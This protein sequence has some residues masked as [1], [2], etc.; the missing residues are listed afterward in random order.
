MSTYSFLIAE[1]TTCVNF[2]DST[3]HA[4]HGPWFAILGECLIEF[5]AVVELKLYLAGQAL[6]S[7]K[8]RQQVKEGR[9]EGLK[10]VSEALTT[11]LAVLMSEAVTSGCG[12]RSP[13]VLEMRAASMGL[14]YVRA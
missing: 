3:C 11:R 1:T 5:V 7:L 2:G 6:V 10:L 13:V 14:Y 9:V 4:P 12:Y 8:S